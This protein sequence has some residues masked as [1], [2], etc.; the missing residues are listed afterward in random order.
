MV[1][2]NLLILRIFKNFGTV[3]TAARGAVLTDLKLGFGN[4]LIHIAITAIEVSVALA[5]ER[6]VV[7]IILYHERIP[8][9]KSSISVMMN[10]T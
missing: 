5:T 10:W 7:R 8:H 9:S 3:H 4:S 2:D 6:F 1:H